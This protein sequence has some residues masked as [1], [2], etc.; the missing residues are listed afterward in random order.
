MAALIFATER[1]S[2]SCPVGKMLTF[3][4]DFGEFVTNG[5]GTKRAGLTGKS[6]TI[7]I[8]CEDRAYTSLIGC[9]ERKDFPACRK[10]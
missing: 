7:E 10:C 9:C 2:L 3:D 6:R 5:G 4:I 1:S 8:V